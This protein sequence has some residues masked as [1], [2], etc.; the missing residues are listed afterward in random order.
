[1]SLIGAAKC[2]IAEIQSV[3]SS[4]SLYFYF[5]SFD[6]FIFLKKYYINFILFFKVYIGKDGSHFVHG[7]VHGTIHYGERGWEG[8]V[9]KINETTKL[10]WY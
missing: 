9:D 10:P 8:T 3:K 2:M 1:M 4:L 5:I 7:G 6:E